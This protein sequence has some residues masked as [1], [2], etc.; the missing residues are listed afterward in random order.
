[1]LGSVYET[2]ITSRSLKVVTE[3]VRQQAWVPGLRRR[4]DPISG[5]PQHEHHSPSLGVSSA[6]GPRGG[7]RQRRSPAAALRRS[8]PG[9]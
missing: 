1:M 6:L 3:L 8:C 5:P 7:T 2:F 9:L 4:V